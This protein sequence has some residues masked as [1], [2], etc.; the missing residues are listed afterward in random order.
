MKYEALIDL[1][2]PNGSEQ[3]LIINAPFAWLAKLVC[4]CYRYG[5]AFMPLAGRVVVGMTVA[6]RKSA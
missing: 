2:Y 6:R 3:T 1:I 4:W 5:P